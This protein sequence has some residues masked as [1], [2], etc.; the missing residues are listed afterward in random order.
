MNYKILIL[1]YSIATFFSSIIAA[2]SINQIQE[3]KDTAKRYVETLITPPTH[4]TLNVVSGHVDS[5][6]SLT[7]CPSAL[8]S[9]IPGRQSLNKSVTVL[10]HCEED[11]W[12][13]YIPVE[14]RLMT[15]IIVA[16]RPLDRGVTL[17]E[18]DLIIQMVD[19]RFQRGQTYTNISDLIGA[20]IKRVVGIG[21]PIQGNDICIV[22]RND[23]VLIKASNNGLN[24]LTKGTALSDGGLGEQIKIRNNKSKRIVDATIT[25]VGHVSIKF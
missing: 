24:I 2:A 8:K 20:R 1:I 7:N 23:E 22:C 3:V 5:R 13:V 4:G 12:Q 15:P 18:R 25:S 19:S 16:K 14:I 17:K 9:T 21:K 11:N 10:I 6:L